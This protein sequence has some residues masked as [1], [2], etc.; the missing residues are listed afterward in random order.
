MDNRREIMVREKT[1]VLDYFYKYGLYIVFTLLLLFFG[2]SS[3][4]YFSVQN[5]INLVQ[6]SSSMGIAC[7][8]MAFVIITGNIDA[9]AG[10]T[11]FFSTMVT[12]SLVD[13]GLGFA[14]AIA[15][16][17]LC[18]IVIGAVNGT[19]VAYLKI[20][21]FM[22]TLAM[23]FILRGLGLVVAD[24][25]L[26]IFAGIVPAIFAETKIFGIIPLIAAIF[27]ALMVSGHIVLNNTAF[28]RELYAIGDNRMAT[29]KAGINDK[30]L[31]LIAYII[32]GA[33]AGLAGLIAG[34]Q[35]GL[36]TAQYG[37]GKEF[38][39][40]CATVLGGISLRG[41]RGQLLPGALIGVIL[42]N[43]IENGLVFLNADPYS[44]DIVRGAVIFLAVALDSTRN[45]GELR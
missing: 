14:G 33:L 22:C 1:T 39:V 7:V 37:V 4:N 2:L 19:L 36:I 41:G 43:A 27:I 3:E 45:R 24:Y 17:L 31:I 16:A 18:G 8:G 26:K 5:L 15:M 30:R 34:A 20:G 11:M 35:V 28:G 44:Y 42:Y 23:Q 32:C 25:K 40:I 21:S 29:W 10:S 6:Q 12:V 38:I 13:L 9:S